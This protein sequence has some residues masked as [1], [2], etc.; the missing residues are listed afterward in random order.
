MAM[1]VS[2]Q[3][4]PT[5]QS[6]PGSRKLLA[7]TS[8]IILEQRAWDSGQNRERRH[9]LLAGGIIQKVENADMNLYAI[10]Q[11]A[12]GSFVCNAATAKTGV[13]IGTTEIDGF[14]VIITGAKINF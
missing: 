14:Q 8:P 9:R 2:F 4:S 5:R 1:R 3:S 13:P 11:F 10:Y 6:T 7:Y 12:D